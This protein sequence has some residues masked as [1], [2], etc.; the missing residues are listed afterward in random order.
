MLNVMRI[1]VID[2]SAMLLGYVSDDAR[3]A[4]ESMPDLE[5][6]STYPP[7]DLE[8]RVGK[9]RMGERAHIS[10]GARYQIFATGA[11]VESEA[12]PFLDHLQPLTL[13]TS[14]CA[15]RILLPDHL[16]V[17]QNCILKLVCKVLSEHLESTVWAV[18]TAFESF[19][20]DSETFAEKCPSLWCRYIFRHASSGFTP[21]FLHRYE[22]ATANWYP[23]PETFERASPPSSWL[24]LPVPINFML[25]RRVLDTLMNAIPANPEGILRLVAGSRNFMS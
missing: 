2:T 13:P 12:L 15:L 5:I 22:A 24:V 10:I 6:L 18:P 1:T 9:V 14:N 21:I 20:E 23:S 17:L 3:H 8:R 16:S 4:I 25:C 11:H 7:R 19:L